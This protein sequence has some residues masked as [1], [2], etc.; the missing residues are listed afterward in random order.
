MTQEISLFNSWTEV[1]EHVL[2]FATDEV[3]KQISEKVTEWICELSDALIENAV[4]V[5]SQAD[6]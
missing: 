1:C 6:N 5:E 3:N 2:E 4:S